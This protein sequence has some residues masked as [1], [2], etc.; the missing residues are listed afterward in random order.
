MALQTSDST[1]L[2]GE[3]GGTG[4]NI[5]QAIAAAEQAGGVFVPQQ[6]AQHPAAFTKMP[7]FLLRD[8]LPVIGGAPGGRTAAIALIAIAD[9]IYGWHKSN[10]L[11]S[12]SQLAKMT[13]MSRSACARAVDDLQ[14]MGAIVV[15]SRGRR[16]TRRIAIIEPV[17]TVPAAGQSG[18]TT[19]PPAGQS[20][21]GTVPPA[22]TQ[23]KVKDKRKEGHQRKS[24]GDWRGDG[25]HFV[26]GK[27]AE[28]IDS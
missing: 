4:D 28:F 26:K 5:E 17:H 21:Q 25:M 15:L 11:V 8:W 24:G 12:V 18:E 9:L 14:A 19:V 22:G 2:P 13:G 27:Y 16:N 20:A 1:P 10:D 7:H 23:K 3:P 6:T